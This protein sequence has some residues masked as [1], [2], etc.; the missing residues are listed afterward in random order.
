VSRF[1]SLFLGLSLVSYNVRAFLFCWLYFGLLFG[2]LFFLVLGAFLVYRAGHRAV[3]WM[4]PAVSGS[5][6]AKPSPSALL[7]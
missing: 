7:S 3:D 1:A 4:A 2:A 6:G 5:S